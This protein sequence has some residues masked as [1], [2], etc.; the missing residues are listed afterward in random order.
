M[1]IDVTN[2]EEYSPASKASYIA[3]DS[4]K[5]SSLHSAMFLTHTIASSHT[6]FSEANIALLFSKWRQKPIHP[7]LHYYLVVNMGMANFTNFENSSKINEISY[8]GNFPQWWSGK[9]RHLGL[10]NFNWKEKYFETKIRFK[11]PPPASVRNVIILW[12]FTCCENVIWHSGV[13][14]YLS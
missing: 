5:T 8:N 2:E 10:W 14:Y 4:N 11:R 12:W 7:M 1:E 13:L 6:F 3:T 9:E